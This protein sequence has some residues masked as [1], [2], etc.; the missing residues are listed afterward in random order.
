ML[1]QHMLVRCLNVPHGPTVY[2][3]KVRYD[4]H[5]VQDKIPKQHA[6]LKQ[7]MLDPENLHVWCLEVPSGGTLGYLTGMLS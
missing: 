2:T 4:V 5:R 3:A 1:Q 6:L 7:K